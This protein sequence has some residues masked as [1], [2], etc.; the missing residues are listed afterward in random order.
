[1]RVRVSIANQRVALGEER[2]ALGSGAAMAA[3][4][5]QYAACTPSSSLSGIARVPLRS[6]GVVAFVS[7]ALS[8]SQRTGAHPSVRRWPLVISQAGCCHATRARLASCNVLHNP[9]GAPS[10]YNGAHQ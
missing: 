1:M 2:R 3:A 4:S 6:S 9:G 7:R 10:R 8:V 5:A